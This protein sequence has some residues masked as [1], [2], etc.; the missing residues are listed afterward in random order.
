MTR[1]LLIA[2]RAKR[3]AAETALLRSI[4]VS[5]C[6]AALIFARTPLGF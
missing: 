5:G 6:A 4:M 1:V 2:A 3:S